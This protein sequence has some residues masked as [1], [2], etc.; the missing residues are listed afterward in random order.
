MADDDDFGE[1]EDTTQFQ[2][3]KLHDDDP[4]SAVSAAVQKEIDTLQ[5][6][7]AS[8]P[9]NAALHS[10][11]ANVYL[12]S[13]QMDKALAS[14]SKA[15]ELQPNTP[16]YYTQKARLH[17]E[18]HESEEA[19]ALL[20]KAQQL[21]PNDADVLYEM[22][23]AYEVDENVAKAREF[24]K[25][26]LEK[27]DTHVHALMKMATLTANDSD[28]KSKDHDQEEALKLFKKVISLDPNHAPAYFHAGL[29]LQA[30]NKEA[31]MKARMNGVMKKMRLD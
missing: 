19:F 29:I 20:N 10:K 24:Y 7:L 30:R 14:A 5:A 9:N 23:H 2:K 25:L 22:G 11:L 16:E 13:E 27:K 12:G 3:L 21:A 17:L 28:A 1:V 8:E 18:V 15:I 31:D 26:A 4:Q 6:Q